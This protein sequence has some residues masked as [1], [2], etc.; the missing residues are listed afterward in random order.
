MPPTKDQNAL[1]RLFDFLTKHMYENMLPS[2]LLDRALRVLNHQLV[3]NLEYEEVSLRI[4]LP[5]APEVLCGSVSASGKIA[6]LVWCDRQRCDLLVWTRATGLAVKWTTAD[7]AEIKDGF[8]PRVFFPDGSEDPAV[9]YG[10][11]KVRWGDMV[12]DEVQIDSTDAGKLCF[13]TVGERKCA[14]FVTGTAATKK[15]TQVGLQPQMEEIKAYSGMSVRWIGVVQM[16]LATIVTIRTG[17]GSSDILRWNGAEID[18]DGMVIVPESVGRPYGKL[19]CLATI[20]PENYEVWR[21]DAGNAVRR[22]IE[23]QGPYFFVNGRIF[24]VGREGGPES[25]GPYLFEVRHGLFD[26]VGRLSSDSVLNRRT[27]VFAVEG[28]VAVFCPDHNTGER[29]VNL[30]GY[31]QGRSQFPVPNTPMDSPDAGERA[32]HDGVGYTR[33]NRFYWFKSSEVWSGSRV[34]NLDLP[35][36]GTP[37]ERLTPLTDEQGNKIVMSWAVT[38][39]TFHVLNY[40]LPR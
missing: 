39:R 15:L 6:V 25:R 40:P 14:A 32:F 33:N 1:K 38:D 18:T 36:Y 29:V 7:V 27:E 9:I 37:F 34:A 30:V 8:K 13:W 31:D 21:D 19:R 5:Y 26:P 10:E 23:R 17:K 16:Q 12:F 24:Y 4:P 22:R 3:G 2:W 20:E 28:A 35:L 11:K